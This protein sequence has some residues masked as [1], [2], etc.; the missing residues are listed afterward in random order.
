MRRAA[1]MGVLVLVSVVG[2]GIAVAA[3]R[4]GE[5]SAVSGDIAAQLVGTPDIRQCGA[6]EDNTLRVRR[7]SRARSALP[8]PAWPVI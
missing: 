1:Y 4:S 8:T 3:S 2:A 7:R 5:V 6:P